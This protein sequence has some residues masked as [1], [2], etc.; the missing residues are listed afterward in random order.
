MVS[1]LYKHS[2]WLHRRV[3][4]GIYTVEAALETVE[5]LAVCVDW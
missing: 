2:G 4:L 3:T 1:A 5:L